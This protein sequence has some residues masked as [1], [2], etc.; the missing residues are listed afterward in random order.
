MRTPGAYPA[1]SD[2]CVMASALAAGIVNWPGV[3]PLASDPTCLTE[4][5]SG[6][7][8]S[9]APDEVELLRPCAELVCKDE[10]AAIGTCKFA[11]SDPFADPEP[12]AL[13]S[14]LAELE[15]P[16]VRPWMVRLSVPPVP[17]SLLGEDCSE[18]LGTIKAAGCEANC[19]FSFSPVDAWSARVDA[20]GA[21]TAGASADSEEG[22]C[23]PAA[24]TEAKDPD[25][26]AP[27]P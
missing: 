22:V 10:D 12:S 25:C 11:V 21:S 19:S 7:A 17:N 3:G 24:A 6:F 18:L 4:A 14:P 9:E 1:G 20:S 26:P 5:L 13:G 16:L 27:V 2:D 23:P 8:S 15:L